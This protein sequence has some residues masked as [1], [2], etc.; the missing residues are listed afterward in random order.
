MTFPRCTAGQLQAETAR[1]QGV[2]YDIIPVTVRLQLKDGT[3][4]DY[5]ATGVRLHEASGILY[6]TAQER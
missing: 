1:A 2:G 3:T 4:Q 5:D 6:V